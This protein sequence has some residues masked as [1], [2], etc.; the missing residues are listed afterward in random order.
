MRTWLMGLLII[1]TIVTVGCSVAPNP[2][3]KPPVP[4]TISSPMVAPTPVE[5]EVPRLPTALTEVTP[6]PFAGCA[7]TKFP[8]EDRKQSLFFAPFA[9][10][11]EWRTIIDTIYPVQELQKIYIR[12]KLSH[13]EPATVMA[14][15]LGFFP[16]EQVQ[17]TLDPTY[18]SDH[19]P[20]PGDPPGAVRLIGGIRLPR[21]GCWDF[22]IQVQNLEGHVIV[23]AD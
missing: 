7:R 4:L 12:A 20:W 1:M 6:T 15:R 11:L 17:T 9:P 8:P 13:P 10:G 21:A 3:S 18:P 16:L 5:T 19:D 22:D 23:L 14:T 2:T